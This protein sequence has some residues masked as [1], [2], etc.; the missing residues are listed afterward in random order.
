MSQP[1]SAPAGTPFE[2]ASSVLRAAQQPPALVILEADVLWPSTKCAGPAA[3]DCALCH[4]AMQRCTHS[5]PPPAAA[6]A[7]C[8]AAIASSSG[9][10]P[11]E[12]AVAVANVLHARGIK[13]AVV[14]ACDGIQPL[15]QRHFSFPIAVVSVTLASQLV[16]S[17]LHLCT[18]HHP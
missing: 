14:S 12:H 9:Q 7:S 17:A 10:P 13:V 16:H 15:L 5:P 6:P 8:S 4:P 18:H 3:S 2:E 11:H 1:S